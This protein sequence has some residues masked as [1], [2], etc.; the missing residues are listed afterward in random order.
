MTMTY[1]NNHGDLGILLKIISRNLVPPFSGTTDPSKGSSD[2]LHRLGT[3]EPHAAPFNGRRECLGHLPLEQQIFRQKSHKG[4]YWMNRFIM[5]HPKKYIKKYTG[6]RV[7]H[8][9]FLR[10]QHILKGGFKGQIPVSFWSEAANHWM[11]RHVQGRGNTKAPPTSRAA[12]G[13]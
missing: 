8:S 5:V 7:N 2:C 4:L 3:A 12:G 6:W 10:I 1:W 13:N 9:F 11:P